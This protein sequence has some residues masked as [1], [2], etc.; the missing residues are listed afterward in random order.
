MRTPELLI[1]PHQDFHHRLIAVI[2]VDHERALGIVPPRTQQ[3]YCQPLPKA[4]ILT[5]SREAKFETW[6]HP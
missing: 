4:G 1:L 3:F 2:S 6:M 5:C